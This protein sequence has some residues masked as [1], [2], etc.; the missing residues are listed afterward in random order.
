MF[1]QLPETIPHKNK[2]KLE[3]FGTALGLQ[4]VLVGGLILIQMAMPERLGEF[5]LLTTLYMAPPPPPPAA[6]LSTAPEPVHHEQPN[7]AVASP[8]AV[9]EER[10]QTEEQPAII[11]PTTVPKDIARIVEPGSPSAGPTAGVSG[12]VR[13]GVPGGVPGGSFGGVLGGSEKGLEVPPPPPTGPVRVGGNVKPPKI[14]HIEQPQY[15]PAARSAGITGVVVVEATVTADG[16]V[17]QVKVI[18]GPALLTEAAVNAVSHWKY[19]PTYLNGQAVPVILTA[20]I[21]FSRDN[22]G[23]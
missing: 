17:E 18:S 22:A 21:T 1:E 11:A 3:A 2:R 19:E 15:P 23:K 10:P 6:P 5:Q 14:V 13:G 8:R 12:G 16:T 7:G 20:R 4:A 9:V